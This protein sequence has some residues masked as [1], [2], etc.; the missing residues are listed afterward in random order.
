MT[1]IAYNICVVLAEYIA[2]TFLPC[3]TTGY[4]VAILAVMMVIN[5]K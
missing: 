2:Q 4:K 3:E 1:H 5:E